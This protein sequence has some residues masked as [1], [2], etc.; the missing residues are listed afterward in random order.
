MQGHHW[1]KL[2]MQKEV[3]GFWPDFHNALRLYGG[4]LGELQKAHSG[5]GN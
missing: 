1:D 5:K 4:C 2:E 3:S